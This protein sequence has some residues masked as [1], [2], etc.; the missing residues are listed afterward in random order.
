MQNSLLNTPTGKL[1]AR[2]LGLK[3]AGHSGKNNSITDVAGVKVGYSTIIKGEGTLNVGEGPIRTGV[4]A[5]LPRSE[6]AINVPVF[7]G[8]NSFNGNGELSGA[9]YIE[10][11]GQL[12]FPITITNTH[13]C[14]VTRDATL[15]WVS[16]KMPNALAEDFALPV[17]A[18]TYDGFLNDINGFHVT[19]E[20]VFEAIDNATSGPIEEGSVGGGTGMKCFEFKAGSGTASR[21]VK[22]QDATYTLGVFVQANFGKRT[23]LHVLGKHVGATLTEP[24]MQRNTPV[25]D[26][27]SIIVVIA[28]DAPLLPHQLKRLARRSTLGIGRLGTIGNHSS[29]DLFLAFSTQNTQALAAK[30]DAAQDLKFIGDQHLDPLFEAVVQSVE[31]AVINS[32]V[33]NQTMQG[34]DGNTVPA[35][36]HDVLRDIALQA[37]IVKV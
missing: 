10:E 24:K 5:I 34:R 37:E 21:L 30:N 29:G 4:T 23:D 35:I 28:T 15:Q 19:K 31:E 6:S 32:M 22:F 33:A 18:E 16:K 27:S 3:F 1:R 17:A 14:G 36:P 12:C 25:A 7:A 20:H 2:S 8:Y 26:L 9:H 13:S 11:V